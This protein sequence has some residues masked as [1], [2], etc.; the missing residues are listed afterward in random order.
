MDT[1]LL[2]DLSSLDPSRKWP[3]HRYPHLLPKDVSLRFE[4]NEENL[5]AVFVRSPT[6]AKQGEQ[7]PYSVDWCLLDCDNALG[8]A[9]KYYNSIQV[10]AV[11]SLRQLEQLHSAHHNMSF[12]KKALHPL[13][14]FAQKDGRLAWGFKKTKTVMFSTKVDTFDD[15]LSE[16]QN[17]LHC[18]KYHV[19]GDARGVKDGH[20]KDFLAFM[21]DARQAHL[22]RQKLSS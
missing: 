9:Q 6:K 2:P 19:V 4:M 13:I 17:V 22:Q 18:K 14:Y 11:C 8:Q 7:Y 20:P 16:G 15:I 10:N 5:F 21:E 1:V 12:L 3:G